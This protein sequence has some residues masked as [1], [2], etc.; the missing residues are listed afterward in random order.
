MG[1]HYAERLQAMLFFPS[2]SPRN[3]SKV[4]LNQPEIRLYLPYSDWFGTQTYAVRLDPNQSEN[5]KYNLISGWFNKTLEQFL[6][7]HTLKNFPSKNLTNLSLQSLVIYNFLW[8]FFDNISF[9]YP[10]QKLIRGGVNLRRFNCQFEYVFFMENF[11]QRVWWDLL[12]RKS[13]LI[14]VNP[15]LIWIVI[16]LHR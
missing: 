9:S 5:G 2:C 3:F 10:C 7:V 1:L 15:N 11:F 12:T 13:F 16:T 8:V 14:L 4:L 6:Y